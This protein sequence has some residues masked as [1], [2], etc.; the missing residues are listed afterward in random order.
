MTLPQLPLIGVTGDTH[1]EKDSNYYK[2]GDKYMLSV[3]RAAGGLA[4]MIPP[5]ADELEMDALLD[6]LDGVV[7]TGS[8]ANLDPALYGAEPVATKGHRDPGRDAT[9]LPLM[10]RVMERLLPLY[11]LKPL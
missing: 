4:V 2:V 5:I 11:W 7:F 6:H 10:K 8:F 9:N 3:V 1:P